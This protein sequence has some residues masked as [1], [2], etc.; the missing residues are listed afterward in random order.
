MGEGVARTKAVAVAPLTL[1]LP[2]VPVMKPE[3]AL[4]VVV[5]AS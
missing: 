3:V 2:E 5:S 1:K 4:S